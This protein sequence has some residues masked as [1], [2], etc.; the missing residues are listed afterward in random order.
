[1][2][3]SWACIVTNQPALSDSVSLNQKQIRLST[4]TIVIFSV[5]RVDIACSPL[6]SNFDYE[7]LFLYRRAL[8][9]V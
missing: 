5:L 8:R 3:Y 4:K 2:A 7:I 1:M 6:D 9:G